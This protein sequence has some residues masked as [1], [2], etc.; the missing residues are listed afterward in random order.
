MELLDV[1]I[2]SGRLL[3]FIRE[4]LQIRKEEME[5]KADWEVW[6]HK[7]WN[8]DWLDFHASRNDKNSTNAAPTHEQT[9]D[10][11]KQSMSI[12]GG[13]MSMR[14]GGQNGTVQTDGNDS[15]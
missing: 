8:Q 12:M 10:I 13:F 1:M 15:G 11:V 14:G 2:Q 6:L 7:V 9:A 3:E 5:E 4:M